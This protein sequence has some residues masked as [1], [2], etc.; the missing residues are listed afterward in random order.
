MD[1]ETVDILHLLDP[2]KEKKR[3]EYFVPD[4]EFMEIDLIISGSRKGRMVETSGP[5]NC[6]NVRQILFP[7]R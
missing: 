1:P 3:K 4:P 6:K 5:S 7:S 2:K